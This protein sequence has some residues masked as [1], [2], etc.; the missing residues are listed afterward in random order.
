MSSTPAGVQ[1]SATHQRV[2]VGWVIALGASLC[3]SIATPISR[4]ALTA[5]VGASEM[6]VARMSLATL[7][8]GLTI[9]VMDFKLLRTDARCF[10]I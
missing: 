7:F 5:G 4:G 6:L 9:G 8:M 10:W 1:V 3:F 2:W